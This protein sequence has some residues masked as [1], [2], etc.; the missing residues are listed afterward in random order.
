MPPALASFRPGRRLATAHIG[1]GPQG[2]FL[3]QALKPHV[4][5]MAL[6]DV[7]EARL[8]AATA[9]VG[10]EAALDR[11]F[12]AL[13][14]RRDIEAVVIATPVHWHAIMAI[15]ACLAGKHVL[16][17]APACRTLREGQ[18]LMRIARATARVVQ[19]GVGGAQARAVHGR[20][21]GTLPWPPEKAAPGPLRRATCRG[22]DN[23]Q[24]GNPD[25][26]AAPPPGLDWDRWLGP[27]PEMPYNPDRIH[28]GERWLIGIGGGNVLQQGAILFEAAFT[29]GQTKLPRRIA[30][31]ASGSPQITGLWD[32]PRALRAE[33]RMEDTSQ[34]ITWV[35]DL[36]EQD[37][38][39]AAV[40]CEGTGWTLRGCDTD[41]TLDPGMETVPEDAL[42]GATRWVK[43]VL[44]YQPDYPAL[45]RA[46]FG[47]TL[48]IL[49]N[50][51]YRTGRTLTWDAETG[52]F[53]ND[54][55]ADRLLHEPGRGTWRL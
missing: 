27:L 28:G 17:E 20:L 14:D 45:E 55:L 49:A 40:E 7:D 13:L 31:Q 8:H 6:C 41:A 12:R 24:G 25:G 35:Q 34:A 16:L 21:T 19:V 47:A 1:L 29:P 44:E 3:L 9:L 42:P 32:C 48:G 51:S 4:V 5:P 43:A 30:V 52:R 53:L 11:D 37:G 22:H 10:P 2:R 36:A 50:L 39:E 46:V 26:D 15:E 18:E 38:P 23:P 54:P 33:L